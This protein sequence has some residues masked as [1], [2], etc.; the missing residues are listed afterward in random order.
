MSKDEATTDTTTEVLRR[1]EVK[2]KKLLRIEKYDTEAVDELVEALNE[3]TQLESQL[4]A[5]KSLV[6]E[7]DDLHQF[8]WRQG[9]GEVLALHN[10]EDGHL[11][12][13]MLHI[14]RRN[15]PISKAIRSEAMKRGIQVP[16]ALDVWDNESLEWAE[17]AKQLGAIDRRDII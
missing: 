2:Y 16:M 3:I 14:L 15:D 6:N 9:T 11:V 12:N 1:G 7:N 4:K 13:I 10:V 8:V 5:L 17:A